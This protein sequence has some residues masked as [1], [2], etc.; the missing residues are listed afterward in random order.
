[1]LLPQQKN[2]YAEKT[3]KIYNSDGVGYRTWSMDCVDYYINQFLYDNNL[4][5]AVDLKNAV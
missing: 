1:M 3:R 5:E 4:Q 2:T